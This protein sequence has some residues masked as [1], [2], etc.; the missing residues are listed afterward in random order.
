MTP[1]WLLRAALVLSLLLPLHAAR[2]AHCE[3]LALL[4]MAS[5]GRFKF[6]Q[7][8]SAPDTLTCALT[9]VTQ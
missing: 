3:K 2:A 5:P 4:A 8:G 9:R 7:G 1:S 6:E